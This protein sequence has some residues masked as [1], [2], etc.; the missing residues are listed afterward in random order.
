MLLCVDIGNTSIS[1]GWFRNH[2]LIGR[3]SIPTK[4]RRNFA[5]LK[6]IILSH[7]IKDAIICSVVP[8]ATKAVEQDILKLLGQ[9]PYVLGKGITAPIK[10][11]Y[12]NPGQ[13]GQDR[14]VA[15]FAASKI[16]GAPVIVVD[17]GTATTFDV[18]SQ[19]G[20]YL[21][22]VIFPGVGMSLAAL[23]ERTALLPLV[24]FKKPSGI[25]GRDT[26]ASILSGINYGFGSLADEL[27]TRISQ[28]LKQ[29]FSVVFTGGFAPAIAGY[30]RLVHKIDVNLV[31]KGLQL[32]Y[33]YKVT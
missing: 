5:Q 3:C 1:L 22:G 19:K 13:V 20:E 24:R 30:S 6:K 7:K 15:A 16:Y 33:S 2:R 12:H 23:S 32:V 9:K 17:F 10:N 4:N 25:V 28:Q 31:L 18:V 26:R 8:W 29:K 14:L 11:L 27:I 21:G